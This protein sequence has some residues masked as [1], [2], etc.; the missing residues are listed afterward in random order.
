MVATRII[1]G[2][3]FVQPL[4]PTAV[5]TGPYLAVVGDY[6][7]VDTT[8]GAVTVTLPTAPADLSVIGVKLVVKGGSN[9]VTIACGG[10]DVINVSGTT[11]LTLSTVLAGVILQYIQTAAIWI[12]LANSST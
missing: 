12:V 7:R 6:V 11:T 4:I 2:D 10:S 8:L 1:A 3:S 5:K 9:T